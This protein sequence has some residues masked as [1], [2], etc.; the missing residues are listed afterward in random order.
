MTENTPTSRKPRLYIEC[1]HTMMSGLNTGIQ[2][3]VREVIHYL[4]GV[5]N[6]DDYDI[7]TIIF[8][9]DRFIEKEFV[10]KVVVKPKRHIGQYIWEFM[11]IGFLWFRKGLGW[12]F[13]EGR[14]K[15]FIVGPKYNNRTL[16]YMVGNYLVEPVFSFFR[17]AAELF[18]L[19]NYGQSSFPHIDVRDGDIL[20]LLDSSWYFKFWSDIKRFKDQGGKI[21]NIVYDL[22]PITHPQFCDEYLVHVFKTYFFTSMEYVDKYICISETVAQDLA[23]FL[24][25]N[26]T[27]RKTIPEI[28]FFHLGSDFKNKNFQSDAVNSSI[29]AMFQKNMPIYLIVS[30][31]EPRKNHKYLLDV[32]DSL[33][34][35]NKDIGLCIVGRIGWK[36]DELINTIL[37]HPQLGK[38]LFMF[39]EASDADVSYCYQHSKGLLFPSYVEGFGLPIIEGLQRG[40]PVFASGTKIHKEVGKDMVTYFDIDDPKS[41]ETQILDHLENSSK[42]QVRSGEIKMT[43][44]SESA[45]WLWREM[46]GQ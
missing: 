21:F 46:E 5:V 9:K 39:N 10:P 27:T 44:W 16:A 32:F 12:F 17:W 3:V 7:K 13:P 8:D 25:T 38:R 20:L 26:P 34:A 22:I 6:P 29:K 15:F 18:N 45:A 41:L 2:R 31:L 36:V 30:T 23:V 4:P 1:T 35:K 14:A 24:K 11:K 40:L 19:K 43:N 37:K 33:W 42:Y 28:S